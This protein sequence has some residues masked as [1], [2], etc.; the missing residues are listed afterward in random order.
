VGQKVNPYGIRLGIKTDWK[1]TWFFERDYKNFLIEDLRLRKL[2]TN[3]CK[4]Q[5]ISGLSRVEIRRKIPTEIWVTARTARPGLLIGRQGKGIEAL[6]RELEQAVGKQVH[7]NVE[8]VKDF[9]LDAQLI[10][11][12]VAEQIEKRG[13]VSR[14]M[15]RAIQ[16]TMKAGA[17][18]VRVKCAGRLGGGEIARKETQKEGRIPLSTLRAEIDYGV[19]EAKTAYGNIGVKVWLCTDDGRELPPAPIGPVTRR[20]ASFAGPAPAVSRSAPTGDGKETSAVV[21]SEGPTQVAES[22]EAGQVKGES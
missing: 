15:K 4:R 8:E 1:S 13:S 10:A 7:I 5:H 14:V 21:R 18:G 12:G 3:Y 17:K 19:T 16:D 9:R 6:R 20:E 2:I 22:F 11:E